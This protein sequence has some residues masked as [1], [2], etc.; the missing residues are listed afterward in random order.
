MCFGT[1][2]EQVHAFCQVFPRMPNS[3]LMLLP[4]KDPSEKNSWI[5]GCK[6]ITIAAGSFF[7]EPKA[8]KLLAGTHHI[9]FLNEHQGNRHCSG[10]GSVERRRRLGWTVKGISGM[11]S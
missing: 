9:A 1:L 10:H 2:W 4:P 8:V 11:S 3:L 7:Q 6:G 5:S